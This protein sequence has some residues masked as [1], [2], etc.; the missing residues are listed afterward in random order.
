[1]GDAP[2]TV[3]DD[4]AEADYQGVLDR[5][6]QRAEIYA[7]MMRGEDTRM[8]CAA[9][10]Q[11]AQFREARVRREAAFR[12]EPA[13]EVDKKLEQERAE[14]DQFDDFYFGAFLVDYHFDDFDRRTS[15]WRIALVGEGVEETPVLVERTGRS[16]LNLRSI[17]PYAG[18]LWTGYHI[19]F[20]KLGSGRGDK[21]VLRLAS[22]LGRVE[23]TFPSN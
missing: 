22:T 14:A 5:Y 11:S 18:E 7:G 15:A 1:M 10:Y 19:R 9:T 4:R 17:Y 20:N 2:S 3:E 13:A 8:F 21:I 16:T 12:V 6:S 23:M